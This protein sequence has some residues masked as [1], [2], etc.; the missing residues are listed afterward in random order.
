MHTCPQWIRVRK[1]LS[2]IVI[3]TVSVSD[4]TGTFGRW[5]YHIQN[6]INGI[7]CNYIYHNVIQLKKNGYSVHTS[8]RDFRVYDWTAGYNC[9]GLA[10]KSMF[11]QFF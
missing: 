10:D 7:H 6:I 2:G 1:T 5:T 11:G 9:V 8:W 4:C 3:N